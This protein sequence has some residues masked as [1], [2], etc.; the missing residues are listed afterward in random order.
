MGNYY[1]ALL[2][3]ADEVLSV[4]AACALLV[5]K[6]VPPDALPRL[7]EL[8]RFELVRTRARSIFS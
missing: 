2:R 1:L 3:E 6:F 4:A 8:A 7:Q 5:S